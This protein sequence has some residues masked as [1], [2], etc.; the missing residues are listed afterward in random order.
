MMPLKERLLEH[1]RNHIKTKEHSL[2]KTSN[3]LNESLN[4]ETKSSAGDKHETGRAMVQLE[5]EKLAR[6]MLELEQMKKTLQKAESIPSST[7]AKLGSLVKTNVQHFFLAISAGVFQESRETVFCISVG[8]PIG[9]MLLGK[10][11]KHSFRF[12][13]KEY[14]ILEIS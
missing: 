5:Q 6:Q 10:E 1:C 2:Q 11:K 12:N 9:Q 7:T 14:L 4:T 3:S 8:S 13:N